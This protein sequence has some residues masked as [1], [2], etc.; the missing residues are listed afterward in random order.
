MNFSQR[1]KQLRKEKGLTLEK[2]ADEFDRS[3]TTFSNYENNHRKPD[4]DLT[5]ELAEYFNVSIDYLLGNT[6]EK[7]TADEIKE[8][9]SE[10]QELFKLWEIISDRKDLQLL[11]QQVKN[12]DSKSINNFINIINIIKKEQQDYSE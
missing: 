2:L 5:I 3:K 10:N 8:V 1:L 7:R 6:E 12:F 9:I 11:L 4:I